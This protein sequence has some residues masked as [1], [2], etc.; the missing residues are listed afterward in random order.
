MNSKK[1]GIQMENK[2]EIVIKLEGKYE[3]LFSVFINKK[4]YLQIKEQFSKLILDSEI[5]ELH[6]KRIR[7][8]KNIKTISK[9]CKESRDKELIRL[10][11]GIEKSLSLSYIASNPDFENHNFKDLFKGLFKL[12]IGHEKRS[13]ANVNNSIEHI[14]EHVNESLNKVDFFEKRTNLTIIDA[15]FKK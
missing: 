4:I 2:K 7:Y 14:M 12:I 3:E 10:A 9:S 11:E 15:G 13:F 1:G 5:K 8:V 6:E